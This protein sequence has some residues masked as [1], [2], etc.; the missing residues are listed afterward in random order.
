MVDFTSMIQMFPET[1]WRKNG[2]E[3]YTFILL[4]AS[5]GMLEA[6]CFVGRG[7]ALPA[8]V[9]VKPSQVHLCRALHWHR[10]IHKKPDLNHVELLV[11]FSPETDTGN[12]LMTAENVIAALKYMPHVK[13][14]DLGA[15]KVIMAS[16][17]EVDR[18]TGDIDVYWKEEEHEDED[19]NEY[20]TGPHAY[21]KFG[22]DAFL[23]TD[24]MPISM[25]DEFIHELT[26]NCICLEELRLNDA[27]RN[28]VV[29]KWDDWE[30][31]AW[32]EK[33]SN[34]RTL[35]LIRMGIDRAI[36][37]DVLTVAMTCT[38]LTELIMDG[39]PIDDLDGILVD[40]QDLY[41]PFHLP[42]LSLSGC[43][44]GGWDDTDEVNERYSAEA[45]FR[46]LTEYT[47][48][49]S[50]DLRNNQYG[51]IHGTSIADALRINTSLTKLDLAFNWIADD[52]KHQ[53]LAAWLPRKAENLV[54]DARNEDDSS[55]DD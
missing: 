35:S 48:L 32:L 40:N 42:S 11:L 36:A 51:D 41:K 37:F 26:T 13:T 6:V 33:L 44:F 53:M 17:H 9:S 28:V 21:I 14:L 23:Q 46:L 31:W 34:L 19:G 1:Q 4:Q 25:A 16:E 5:K 24:F 7:G 8:H 49:T 22:G 50:L 12:Y 45:V 52:V 47:S 39:N 43:G 18:K 55:M 27:M 10:F 54:L 38:T 30:Y 15:L 3:E 20:V 29:C 2:L